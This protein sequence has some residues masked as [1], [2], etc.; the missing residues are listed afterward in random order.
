MSV[1]LSSSS[2]Q[3]YISEL[4]QCLARMLMGWVVQPLYKLSHLSTTLHIWH[5]L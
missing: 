5:E 1:L 3:T 2:T 4:T